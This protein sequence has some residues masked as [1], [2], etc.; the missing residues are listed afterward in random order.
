MTH[1]TWLTWT[2]TQHFLTPEQHIFITAGLCQWLNPHICYHMWHHSY[3]SKS[4][5]GPDMSSFILLPVCVDVKLTEREREKR[6]IHIPRLPAVCFTFSDANIVELR[7]INNLLHVLR[8][9]LITA[10]L[11]SCDFPSDCAAVLQDFYHPSL[12]I[13]SRSFVVEAEIWRILCSDH[14]K[15]LQSH[16]SLSL[17]LSLFPFPSFS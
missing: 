15:L 12:L 3:V 10:E 11:P 17:S 14:T 2:S 16:A 8:C 7:P 5:P 6:G 1:K 4:P 13:L 9:S